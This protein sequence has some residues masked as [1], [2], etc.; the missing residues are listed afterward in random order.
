MIVLEVL[1][2]NCPASKLLFVANNDRELAAVRLRFCLDSL[3]FF[4]FKLASVPGLI[5]VV[6][7]VKVYSNNLPVLRL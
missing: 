6:Y 3:S 2:L 4:F 1:A 5:F 7:A